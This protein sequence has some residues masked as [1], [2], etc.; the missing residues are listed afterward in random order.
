MIAIMYESFVE[1]LIARANK[2]RALDHGTHLF[3][4]SEPV[5]SVFIVEEGLVEL[6]R[7]QQDGASIILQRAKRQSVVAEASIY[8][9]FYHC[10]AVVK[11][12]SRIFALPKANFLTLLRQD[13][14]LSKSWAAHLAREVQSARSQIEIL[15]RKTVSERLDGWFAWQGNDLPP[16]GQWKNIAVLIGVSP[17]ALYRELAKRRSG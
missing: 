9:E 10:D 1:K 5:R 17:E 6:V 3:H 13:E 8:S 14:D 11:L 16:K 12:P 7:H 4:Q 15:S 2:P